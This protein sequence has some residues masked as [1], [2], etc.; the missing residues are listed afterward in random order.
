MKDNPKEKAIAANRAEA[1]RRLA[2]LDRSRLEAAKP[3]KKDDSRALATNRTHARDYRI[4][5]NRERGLEA[6]Q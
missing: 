6:E 2:R 5:R 3:A 1:A 4:E